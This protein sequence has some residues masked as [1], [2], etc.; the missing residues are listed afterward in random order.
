MSDV[1]GTLLN[2]QQQLTPGVEAAVVAAAEAGVPLVV[3]TGKAMGP[4]RDSV[5]PRLGSRLPQVNPEGGAA[6]HPSSSTMPSSLAASSPT[7]ALTLPLPHAGGRPTP[8]HPLLL[9]SR[10]LSCLLLHPADL[11]AGPAH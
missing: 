3:A 8:R 10:S 6:G 2:P 1:D 7:A 11:P 4:W 9:I 5:L